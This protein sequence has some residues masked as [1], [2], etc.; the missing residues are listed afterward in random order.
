[1]CLSLMRYVWFRILRVSHMRFWHHMIFISISCSLHQFVSFFHR[2]IFSERIYI[3][4]VILL[5]H[6]TTFYELIITAFSLLLS[7][8]TFFCLDAS[9]KRCKLVCL[10]CPSSLSPMW[11]TTLIE[12]RFTP[13]NENKILLKTVISWIYEYLVMV[14]TIANLSTS[15]AWQ[16]QNN[17]LICYFF[18][19]LWTD[20]TSH[21]PCHVLTLLHIFTG[22]PESFC[23]LA[24]IPF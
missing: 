2:L 19:F 8:S 21:A 11:L 18:L 7:E 20:Q 23:K 24:A 5:P 14:Y 12:T 13:F 3:R 17:I 10:A 22:K 1:M 9:P 4:L 15:H 6:F 16:P